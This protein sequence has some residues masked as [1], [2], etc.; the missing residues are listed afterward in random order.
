MNL[1]R[2][3]WHLHPLSPNLGTDPGSLGQS[4]QAGR[5]RDGGDSH[6]LIVLYPTLI[7]VIITVAIIITLVI[8]IT[9]IIIINSYFKFM[10]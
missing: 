8:I 4:S 10:A 2:G 5:V 9:V 1:E 7:T 3:N 6:L